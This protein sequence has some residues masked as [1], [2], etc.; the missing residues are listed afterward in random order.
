VTHEVKFG[1][2]VKFDLA[3]A[4]DWYEALEE[5]VGERFLDAFDACVEAI[6][7]N[8]QAFPVTH[9]EVRRAFLR[10][11]PYMVLYRVESGK[12]TVIGCF[13]GSRNPRSWRARR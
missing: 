5:G 6:C 10:R 4:Y 1:P 9:R 12:V 3:E 2:L 11:F 8:P 7:E 13:H